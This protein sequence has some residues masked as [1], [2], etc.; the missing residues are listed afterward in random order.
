MK[1]LLIIGWI[2]ICTVLLFLYERSSMRR[3]DEWCRKH[4]FDTYAESKKRSP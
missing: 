1:A 3:H 4:G 2:T